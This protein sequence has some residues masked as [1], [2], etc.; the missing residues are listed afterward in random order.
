MKGMTHKAEYAT[1]FQGILPT[2][3]DG[4]IKVG[5]SDAYAHSTL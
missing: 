4:Q 5:T 1:Q 3:F 2:V